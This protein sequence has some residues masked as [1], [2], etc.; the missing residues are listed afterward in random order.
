M[1][2]CYDIKDHCLYVEL[3]SQCVSSTQKNM[4]NGELWLESRRELDNIRS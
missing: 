1:H 2:R 3:E 4:Q